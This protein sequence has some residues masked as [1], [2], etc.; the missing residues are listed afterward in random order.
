M[1][2][3]EDRLYGALLNLLQN[4]REDVPEEMMTRHLIDACHDAEDELMPMIEQALSVAVARVTSY[5]E[6]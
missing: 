2:E 1:T 6:T 5:G 3:T 4:L